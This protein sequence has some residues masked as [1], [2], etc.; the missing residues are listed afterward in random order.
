M[1]IFD[2]AKANLGN[3]T[4]VGGHLVANGVTIVDD[5]AGALTA[6]DAKNFRGFGSKIG[7]SWRQVALAKGE[8]TSDLTTSLK[9]MMTDLEPSKIMKEMDPAAMERTMK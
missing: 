9:E 6:Y 7:H 2:K 8:S 3:L 4:F 5:L 1:A